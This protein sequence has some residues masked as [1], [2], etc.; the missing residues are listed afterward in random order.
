MKRTFPALTAAAAIVSLVGVGVAASENAS[1]VINLADLNIDFSSL[2][3]QPQTYAVRMQGKSFDR[4]RPFPFDSTLTLQ[5]NRAG[6]NVVLNDTLEFVGRT[7]SFNFVCEPEATLTPAQGSIRM[8]HAAR[9]ISADLV[10]DD[11]SDTLNVTTQNGRTSAID[12]P[13][14]TVTEAALFRIVTCLPRTPGRTYA[15]SAY[16]PLNE[17]RPSTPEDAGQCTLT[18]RG[19]TTIDIDRTPVECTQYVANFEGD[20]TFFVDAN[21]VVRKVLA[22]FAQTEMTLVPTP[23]NT[24]V[25][26]AEDE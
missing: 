2:P 13:D 22:D 14:D 4:G 8:D 15:F 19:Q 21:N 26:E 18:C 9:T 1:S 24:A 23:S 11:A 3:A 7:F 20:L 5:T 6:S 10:H 12:F 17:V 16:C 25:A